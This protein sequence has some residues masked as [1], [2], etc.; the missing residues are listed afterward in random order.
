VFN[1]HE[2]HCHQTCNSNAF[3]ENNAYE[4]HVKTGLNKA[5]TRTQEKKKNTILKEM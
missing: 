1:F 2:G 3:F 4:L 5:Q